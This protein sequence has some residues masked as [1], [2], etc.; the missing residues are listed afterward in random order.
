MAPHRFPHCDDIPENIFP[1]PPYSVNDPNPPA[2]YEDLFP[3]GYTPFP[4]PNT[5]LCPSMTRQP[6][7]S[8]P[9]DPPP[10]YDS[11]FATAVPPDSAVGP[12][13]F[14]DYWSDPY[15]WDTDAGSDWDL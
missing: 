7:P 3:T 9:L 8:V 15:L 2:H 1:L 11:L 4:N 10:P 14:P 5:H 13:Y 12:P 6:I